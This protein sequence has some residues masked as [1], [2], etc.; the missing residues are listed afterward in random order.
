MFRKTIFASSLL[1]LS[2][3]FGLS[4][5]DDIKEEHVSV[6]ENLSGNVIPV[7]AS[8]QT[9]AT[10]YD[11][12]YPSNSF[13]SPYRPSTNGSSVK[14]TATFKSSETQE[15]NQVQTSGSYWEEIVKN[16]GYL[17]ENGDFWL[18]ETIE[19]CFGNEL[20]VSETDYKEWTKE[21]WEEHF[22]SVCEPP[23][24]YQ[25]TVQQETKQESET[26]NKQK[27]NK[28]KKKKSSEDEWD[29]FWDKLFDDT[30]SG[31]TITDP[32][33]RSWSIVF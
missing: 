22:E 4:S 27:K 2:L 7:S 14:N 21:Q 8:K 19:E 16:G 33:G 26:K 10:E 25:E 32:D 31:S 20:W 15:D 18:I 17:Q 6:K 1:L 28:K 13:Y 11:D 3:F 12:D 29:E 24:G 30:E 9:K 23:E 5:P